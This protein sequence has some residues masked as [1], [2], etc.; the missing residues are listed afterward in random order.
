MGVPHRK[1]HHESFAKFFE[2]PTRESLREL[3]KDRL[4]ETR[5]LDFKEE[6]IEDSKLA[7]HLL[8]FGNSGG[9][10]IVFGVNDKSEPVGLLDIKDDTAFRNGVKKFLPHELLDKVLLL[11]FSY[12]DSEYPILIGKKFQ[13]CII[14][15]DPTKL[16][17]VSLADGK[18]ISS[19]TVYIRRGASSEKAT[20]IELQECINRRLDTGYSSQKELDLQT[21][22]EQLKVLYKHVKEQHKDHI[23][24]KNLFK[25]ALAPILDSLPGLLDQY[26]IVSN[27]KYDERYTEAGFDDFIKK[28]INSKKFRIEV[29]LDVHRLY[30]HD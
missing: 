2:Q 26:T 6:W 9:G 29:E 3:L 30:E 25:E 7:R 24:P 17:Y 4:G 12:K 15:D 14:E 19:N 28:L 22:L 27:P 20:H 21:H 16:P 10:C 8:G 13:I 23:F 11:P 5:E 18:N 1:S